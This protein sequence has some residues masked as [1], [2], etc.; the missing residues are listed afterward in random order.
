MR[1]RHVRGAAACGI[2]HSDSLAVHP[3]EPGEP[4][5]VPG[6]GL[7]GRID[8]VG[9][10]VT[11]WSLGDRVGVGFLGGHCAVCDQCRRGNF[12][13]CTDQPMTGV[14]IDG[15]YAEYAYAR[16]SALVA[17][18]DGL[19]FEEAAPLL[20][21]GF[22]TYNGLVKAPVRPDALVAVQGIGGLGH[23]GVQYARR[24][25]ARVVAVARGT[26]KAELARRLG[27]HHYIDSV[28]A[29]VGA[30]LQ[31][32]GGADLIVATAASGAS[33]TRLIPG[34][35]KPGTLMVLGASHEP[36]EIPPLAL[37]M[38]QARV[39]GLLTGSAIENEDNLRFTADQGISAMIE[40]VPFTDAA[41]AYDR[42]MSGAARF[43]MVLTMS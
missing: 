6:H 34:L 22:T 32:L 5:V 3:H 15:G 23:L 43:R 10:G 26:D 40:Q 21:A 33:M 31:N 19:S 12:T 2:C 20:C 36:I 41:A 1:V 9:E 11:R 35:A 42:M 30:Q 13:S 4:A 14:T 17:I 29:D 25:G 7:A 16:Q 18:P 37:I 38:G 39:L 8:A 28:A 24:M 27:A